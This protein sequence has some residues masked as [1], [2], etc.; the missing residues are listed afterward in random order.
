MFFYSELTNSNMLRLCSMG[1]AS[2]YFFFSLVFLLDLI[3]L[4]GQSYE[5]L[6]LEFFVL[7]INV[8]A[9]YLGERLT[10]SNMLPTR[11]IGIASKCSKTSS[12]SFAARDQRGRLFVGD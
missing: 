1:K 6:S 12:L 4:D 8:D 9:L 5:Y 10:N 2:K 3:S 11:S 7:E